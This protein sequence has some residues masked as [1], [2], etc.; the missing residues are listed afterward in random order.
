[1]AVGS[2]HGAATTRPA[3]V[4]N[5]EVVYIVESIVEI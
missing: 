4:N 5:S 1:V 3:K 2:T